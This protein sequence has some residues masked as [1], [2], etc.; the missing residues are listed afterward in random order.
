MQTLLIAIGAGVVAGSPVDF[1]DV[2]AACRIDFEMHLAPPIT[3]LF[4]GQSSRMGVGAAVSDYDRDGDPDLYLCDAL[5]HPNVLYRN[6]GDGTFTDVTETAGVGD[7]GYGR[8][9]LWVD[10]DN[11]GDDDLVVLNDY[12]D[13]LA[14]STHVY[15]PSQLFRND[16]D[17]TFTNVTAGSGFNP[18]DST[19]GGA[20]AG[21]YDKDGDLDLLVTGWY[22][23]ST[24]L[25]RNDG[26]FTFTDVTDDARLRPTGFR[27]QFTPLFVDVDNDGWQDVFCAV[28]F[29]EDYLFLNN[30]DGTFTDVSEDSGVQH[31]AN[32]MGVAYADID[33]D[34]DIDF[35]NTNISGP[36][37]CEPDW[38]CDILYVNDGAGVFSDGTEGTGLGDVH[39][40]W[41]V[42]FFDADLDTHRDML[43]VNGWTQPEW[44]TPAV[45]FHN[46]GTGRF[47][48]MAAAAGIDYVGN[49]RALTP[50]DFDLD[51]DVD[52][53][54]TDV[55]GPATVHENRS[56]RGDRH[57]LVVT[58]EGVTSNRNGVGSRIYV[59][60]GDL[61]QMHEIVVGGS[62]LAAPALEGHFGL[63]PA[64][65]V[66]EVHVV[67]PSGRTVTLDDVDVDQRLHVVEP[68]A[69]PCRGDLD[70]SG[71]VDV[72]DVLTILGA[73]GPC[74]TCAAD[75]D[76][77]GAV[78]VADL[79]E[80]L[81]AWGSCG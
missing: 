18:A 52:F 38:G 53:V 23:W 35:Y 15:H 59:T 49:T 12:N 42:W 69:A 60:T 71:R 13:F 46:D 29:L 24:Y 77:S 54:M 61:T 80:L 5:G 19:V 64:T 17:G 2:T 39:W 43:A 79:L 7:L 9:A 8:M 22:D 73:W 75:L 47:T 65:T 58:T 6:E 56:P 66:D 81:G 36:K 45:F 32:D 68:D 25:Y 16:G 55:L 26:D 20:T 40:G 33:H 41:G 34:L 76:G 37:Y 1:E 63:G 70:G 31:V 10:L 28:D 44:V 57:W 72:G 14:L 3:G 21:D 78:D 27:S 51:G 67:F 74:D 50:I 30:G 11:D 48:E 62:F 4:P